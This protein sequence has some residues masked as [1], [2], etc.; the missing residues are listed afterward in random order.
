MMNLQ[1]VRHFRQDGTPQFRLEVSTDLDTAAYAADGFSGPEEDRNTG[2]HVLT[3]Y[4]KEVI[5]SSTRPQVAYSVPLGDRNPIPT[6]AEYLIVKLK[7]K[8]GTQLDSTRIDGGTKVTQGS[9]PD[10]TGKPL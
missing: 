4:A 5:T 10:L 7:H 1:L 8:D 9:D 2:E 3:L 6:T